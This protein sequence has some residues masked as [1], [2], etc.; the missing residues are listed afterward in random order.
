MNAEEA[1]RAHA[2]WKEKLS[3]YLHHPDGSLDIAEIDRDDCC[4]LGRWIHG[5]DRRSSNCAEVIS[6]RV[7][8]AEFHHAAA[9]IVRKVDAGEE[10]DAEK[11]LGEGSDFAA[12]AAKVI[13]QIKVAAPWIS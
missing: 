1:I 5:L 2:E 7:V 6:L 8:H 11:L 3:A 10:C 9:A 4:A 12:L 13:A